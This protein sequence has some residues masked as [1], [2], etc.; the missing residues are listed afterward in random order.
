MIYLFRDVISVPD[1][2]I[3]TDRV[4]YVGIQIWMIILVKRNLRQIIMDNY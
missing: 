1:G 3:S 2:V 4:V